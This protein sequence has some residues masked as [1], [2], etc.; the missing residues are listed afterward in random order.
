VTLHSASS[1]FTISFWRPKLFKQL[2]K[3]N[4]VTGQLTSVP[5]NVFKEIVRKGVTVL[6]GQPTRTAAFTRIFEIPAGADTADA[7][8]LRAGLSLQGGV[9]AQVSQ[10]L[11]N[12]LVTG[13][14]G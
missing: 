11:G 10:E 6:A 8:N 3:T 4:P 9:V 14:V 1:P 13:L 7:P 2:G 12:T 5:V